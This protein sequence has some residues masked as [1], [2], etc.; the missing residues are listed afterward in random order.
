MKIR[1]FITELH[2]KTKRNYLERMNNNKVKCMKV[3][4]KYS[5]DYWDGDR[6][7]GYGGYF[8]KKGYW[9]KTALKIIKTYNLRKNSSILDIGCGKGYLLFEIKKIIPSIKIHGIDISKYAI[10]NSK[11]EVRKYLKSLMQEKNF[12][13]KKN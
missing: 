7:F 2:Q 4:K 9:K 11:V 1:N 3:A 8:Y 13:I 10:K 6:K 5:K 12:L